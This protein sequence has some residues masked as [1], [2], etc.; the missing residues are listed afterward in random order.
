[1]PCLQ[2]FTQ[3]DKKNFMLCCPRLRTQVNRTQLEIQEQVLNIEQVPVKAL[4]QT[5]WRENPCQLMIQGDYMLTIY[6]NE[7]GTTS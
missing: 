4:T 3:G 6:K 1:M 7:V 5:N 2:K